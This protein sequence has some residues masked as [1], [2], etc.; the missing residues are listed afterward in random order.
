MEYVI[1]LIKEDKKRCLDL[2][3]LGDEQESMIDRYLENGDLY[4]LNVAGEHVGV[5][6]VVDVNGKVC[7]LKNIAISPKYQ[8]GGLG[9]LLIKYAIEKYSDSYSQM[10]VGTG[11]TPSV[12]Q[13]YQDFGFI[14]SHRI[15]NF[16]VDNYNHEIIEEGVVLRDM[17]Y[18]SLAI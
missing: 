9:Q 5:C 7:E 8:R 14:Y 4:L 16:F 18:F 6:V 1:T 12:M 3:L 13:F 2:L 15:D 11:E 17:I 10:I